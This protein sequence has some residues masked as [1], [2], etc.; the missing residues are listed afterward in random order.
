[1]PIAAPSPPPSTAAAPFAPRWASP[2]VRRRV[3][4]LVAATLL[5]LL[6]IAAALL[7]LTS[8]GRLLLSEPHLLR[9]DVQRLVAT[10]RFTAPLLL[11][12]VYVPLAILALPV[13]WLQ[14]LAGLAFGLAMGTLWSLAGAT[15]GALLTVLLTRW[16]A[17]EYVARELEPRMDRFRKLNATLGHNGFLVVMTL[18][19]IHLLP[20]GL[21]NYAIGISR[22]SLRDLIIGTALGSIPAVATYV[23][24]GAGIRPWHDWKFAVGI[25]TLNVLLLLPLVLRYLRP[26]WFRRIGVE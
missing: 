22:I 25:G 8:T 11:L 26:G 18:R 4:Q 19:L 21:C 6:L 24:A 10:H 16:L 9:A 3:K 5:L 15:I 13:W 17:A 12:A 7:L 2:R 1:M 20:F 14:I 23:A